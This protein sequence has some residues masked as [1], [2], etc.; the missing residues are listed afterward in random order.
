MPKVNS[1]MS[2]PTMNRLNKMRETG[3]IVRTPRRDISTDGSTAWLSKWDIDAR[4][5]H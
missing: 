1:R 4:E 5:H 3:L 2:A